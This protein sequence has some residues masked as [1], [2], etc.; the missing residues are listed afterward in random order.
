[1]VSVTDAFNIG[2]GRQGGPPPAVHVTFASGG[3]KGSWYKVLAAMGRAGGQ[4]A[5]RA[6]SINCRDSF[7]KE[8]LGEVRQLAAKGMTLKRQGKVGGYRVK[9]QGPNCIP[10]LEIKDRSHRGAGGW[11]IYRPSAREEADSYAERVERQWDHM[12]PQERTHAADQYNEKVKQAEA[13]IQ[14]LRRQQE[15]ADRAHQAALLEAQAFRR[16]RAAMA[17][18]IAGNG[19]RQADVHMMHHQVDGQQDGGVHTY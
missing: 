15:E 14:R 5:E 10:V 7:P 13:E 18:V 6:R 2:F 4:A 17:A 19:A 11:A 1:M 8:Y 3:Q 9:A 16:E 12:S